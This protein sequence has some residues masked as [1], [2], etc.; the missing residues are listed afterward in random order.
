MWSMIGVEIYAGLLL[1]LR[2]GVGLWVESPGRD[3]KSCPGS[4]FHVRVPVK[5]RAER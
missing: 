2:H 3:E 4:T 1:V 5:R